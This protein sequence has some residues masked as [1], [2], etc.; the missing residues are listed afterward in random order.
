MQET[1][2]DQLATQELSTLSELLEDNVTDDNVEIDYL[3]EVLNI[4]CARGEYVINKHKPTR[5]IWV[6]SPISGASYFILQDGEWRNKRDQV[7]LR[8]K[9]CSELGL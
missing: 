7:I 2:F 3:D 8:D 5:Q 9:I 1:E 6:S 4:V